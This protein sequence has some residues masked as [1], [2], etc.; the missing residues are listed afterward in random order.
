MLVVVVVVVAV[1]DI[2]LLLLLLLLPLLLILSCCSRS[3]LPVVCIMCLLVLLYG[4]ICACGFHILPRCLLFLFPL[5]RS[6]PHIV[7]SSMAINY[8]PYFLYYLLLFTPKTD[9]SLD[10]AV[11]CGDVR[12]CEDCDHTCQDDPSYEYGDALFNLDDDP[13][14]SHNLI[15]EFP[16][17]TTGMSS[18]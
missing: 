4:H 18:T 9:S 15:Q 14:E 6:S 5:I 16:E 7:F 8:V 12:Q 17:V 1:V 10:S 2:M 13:R 11:T 3:C